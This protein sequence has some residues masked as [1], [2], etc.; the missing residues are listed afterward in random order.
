MHIDKEAKKN[1]YNQ[2]FTSENISK[3]MSSLIDIP[4]N[5]KRIT[6]LDPG[7]GNG[8]LSIMLVRHIVQYYKNISNVKVIAYE[9]DPQLV[10]E[11]KANLKELKD[12]ILIK[13]KVKVSFEIQNKNYL[14]SIE[15]EIKADLTIINPPYGKIKKNS[16]VSNFLRGYGLSSTNYY[17]SFIEVAL[18]HTK[19]KGEIVF[20]VPRSFMNGKYF[21]LFR[22]N[23]FNH[24]TLAR[25]H[26]FES[27]YLFDK[28]TQENVI[29]KLKKTKPNMKSTVDISHSQDDNINSNH[30]I[31]RSITEIIDFDNS[32]IIRAFRSEVDH[33]IR[34]LIDSKGYTL[35]ELKQL[36][37]STGPV[38][39]FRDAINSVRMEYQSKSIPYIFQDHIS[40]NNENVSWPKSNAKKGNF[41]IVSDKVAT[42]IRSKGSYVVVKRFSP[43][44]S[45]HRVHAAVVSN[46]GN[47][48]YVAFDNKLNY[49]HIDKKGMDENVALGLSLYLNS[50][51]VEV[52]ISQI[53]GST[54]INSSDL[55]ILKYPS[56]KE[57]ESIGQI[58]KELN[59]NYSQINI[60]KVIAT[61][62]R[63][64][65]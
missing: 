55:E 31:T 40:E 16:P 39:D 13:Y 48:D 21:K 54:Q 30:M 57:L 9:I 62:L 58:W 36:Q 45:K 11:L 56:I 34:N 26:I 7:A 33:A 65:H 4:S 35:S 61:C 60:N 32:N 43:K 1:I 47:Y 25:V 29:V 3:F 59:L 42:K 28:V 44:E 27:R 12:E 38:V 10:E 64:W 52:Y 20:I 8:I 14:Y 51:L 6:I 2:H 53:T 50:S 5:R 23:V 22:S 17:S 24:T 18:R 49:F 19:N 15:D 63:S 37:V 46:L 41:L